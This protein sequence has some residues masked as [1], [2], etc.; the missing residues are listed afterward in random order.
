V[1]LLGEGRYMDVHQEDMM[2]TEK[3]TPLPAL[4]AAGALALLASVIE[5]SHTTVTASVLSAAGNDVVFIRQR[6]RAGRENLEYIWIATYVENATRKFV[7]C[8]DWTDRP[9]MVVTGLG[10]SALLSAVR[11]IID[12]RVNELVD[13]QT[14]TRFEHWVPRVTTCDTQSTTWDLRRIRYLATGQ[15]VK[16]VSF[17]ELENG[18]RICIEQ[19]ASSDDDYAPTVMWRIG[20][21][22]E[23]GMGDDWLYGRASA[24]EVDNARDALCI[25]MQLNA[26]AAPVE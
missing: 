15:H 10:L 11:D 3:V 14:R 2:V 20:L 13:G 17:V 19:V 4:T 8:A 7:L 25:V 23:D 24:I 12:G 9:V 18:A 21:A 1:H 5:S 26:D 22:T 6:S 16:H